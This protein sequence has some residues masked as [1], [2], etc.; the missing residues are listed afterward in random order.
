MKRNLLIT[1]SLICALICCSSCFTLMTLASIDKENV[2]T[3]KDFGKKEARLELT[4]FQKIAN[5]AALASTGS[6]EVVCLIADFGEY[7]DGM[8]LSGR[9]IG[10]GTYSYTTVSG[11]QKHVL[12]YVYKQDIERLQAI[13][14]EFMK[15]KPKVVV[16]DSIS[17]KQI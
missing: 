11:V 5:Y 1:F 6:G 12:V 4:T 15:E 13:V 9:F 8:K 14:D 3:G 7:Y 17:T 2:A 16:P 10:Q